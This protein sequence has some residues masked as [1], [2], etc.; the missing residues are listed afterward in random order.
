MIASC[1]EADSVITSILTYKVPNLIIDHMIMQM[2][3]KLSSD[4]HLCNSD[5]Q[6]TSC[7]ELETIYMS[8]WQRSQIIFYYVYREGRIGGLGNGL[9]LLG[10]YFQDCR[11]WVFTLP[12]ANFKTG[13]LFFSLSSLKSA[14]KLSLHN[15]FILGYI[16]YAYMINFM[17]ITN[18][19][20]LISPTLLMLEYEV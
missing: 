17:Y 13:L 10:T 7:P 2:L 12:T 19:E 16:F 6:V 5:L 11:S 15:S 14:C 3:S 1:L 9:I 18:S 4:V 20:K 8:E